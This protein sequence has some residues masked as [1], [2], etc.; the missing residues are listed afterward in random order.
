MRAGLKKSSHSGSSPWVN[1]TSSACRACSSIGV[2]AMQPRAQQRTPR[3][4]RVPRYSVE[5]RV[6]RRTV[7][8][9]TWREALV[10]LHDGG[11]R[12]ITGLAHGCPGN[13]QA[14]LCESDL[15]QAEES[16]PRRAGYARALSGKPALHSVSSAGIRAQSQAS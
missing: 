3:V 15:P 9:E 5:Q 10:R 2:H 14:P 7:P 1:S 13:L 16:H 4:A 11:Q 8:S 6:S 12:V